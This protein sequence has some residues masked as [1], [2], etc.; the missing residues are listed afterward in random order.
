[1]RGELGNL[2]KVDVLHNPDMPGKAAP[3]REQARERGKT[4]ILYFG[5][6]LLVSSLQWFVI[7]KLF[8]GSSANFVSFPFS[9]WITECTL[10]FSPSIFS[11]LN[12]LFL[13]LCHMLFSK[14]PVMSWSSISHSFTS[15]RTLLKYLFREAFPDHS[16][17]SATTH[18][19]SSHS[20][21]IFF[22]VL[23]TT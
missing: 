21:Y 7:T 6:R 22:T 20:I 8:A 9:T 14:K 13:F 4:H 5:P 16:F 15:F 18:S 11:L 1:M 19:L 23:I 17:E 12:P 2:Q 3:T 10:P